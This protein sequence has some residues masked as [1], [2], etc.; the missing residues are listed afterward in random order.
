MSESASFGTISEADRIRRF[1]ELLEELGDWNAAV[2]RLKAEIR[3]ETE[4][5]ASDRARVSPAWDTQAGHESE[6]TSRGGRKE[7]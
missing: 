4:T 3:A 6:N 7:T 2:W 1:R 5:A